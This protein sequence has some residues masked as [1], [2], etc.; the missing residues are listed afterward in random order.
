MNWRCVYDYI[1]VKAM[2][3]SLCRA[4]AIAAYQLWQDAKPI[5]N[6]DAANDRITLRTR[7]RALRPSTS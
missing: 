1:A 7:P 2:A 4:S 6:A 5:R 3:G